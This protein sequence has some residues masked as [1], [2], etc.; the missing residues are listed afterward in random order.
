MVMKFSCL[1]KSNQLQPYNKRPLS[2]IATMSTDKVYSDEDEQAFT[3]QR[4]IDMLIAAGYF[5]ARISG[6]HVFDVVVGGMSWAITASGVPV[7]VDVAFK[8]NAN[9]GEKIQI[10]EQICSAL[11]EMQC[12]FA[13]R[14]HQ[15]QGLQLN[16]FPLFPIV[17]W[18]VKSVI[19]Y[20]RITGD[21]VRNYS[22]F[23]FDSSTSHLNADGDGVGAVN[24]DADGAGSDLDGA[25]SWTTGPGRE[26]VVH[27]VADRYRFSRQFS[28]QRDGGGGVALS[29]QSGSSEVDATL[30]EYA[31]H[32]RARIALGLRADDVD[33]A[34]A[35]NGGDGVGDGDGGGG[36]K[37]ASKW[38]GDGGSK[39]NG[40]SAAAKDDGKATGDGVLAV[41]AETA[42]EEEERLSRLRAEMTEEEALRNVSGSTLV[43]II[44]RDA[45]QSGK[46]D[47]DGRWSLHSLFWTMLTLKWRRRC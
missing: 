12:P 2:F 34:G 17:Q 30:L 20:R 31:F 35:G 33:G 11:L 5:R 36:N 42:E 19:D 28:K 4:I 37:L 8:E 18:L 21:T 44:D 45:V 7:A 46:G 24:V 41:S 47:V 15:I 9:I 29:S 13:L 40:P 23:L 26:W 27:S 25:R 14:P 38:G 6:L 3:M 22:R 10:S 1:C 16:C 39:G 32:F 43:G